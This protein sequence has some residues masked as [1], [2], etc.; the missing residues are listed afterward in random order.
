MVVTV[1]NFVCCIFHRRREW[2]YLNFSMPSY[3]RK[4]NNNS[5][6]D[7]FHSRNV[8]GTE[9]KAETQTVPKPKTGNLN[10]QV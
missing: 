7:R 8:F 9:S 10:V 5:R 2:T 6:E 3:R 1:V 4:V